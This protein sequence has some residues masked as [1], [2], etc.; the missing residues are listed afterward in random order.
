ML[1]SKTMMKFYIR[2]SFVFFLT[3]ISFGSFAQKT[4]YFGI[5]VI[6]ETSPRA[7]QPSLGINYEQRFSKR[8]GFETDILY[9]KYIENSVFTISNGSE[10]NTSNIRLKESHLSIPALYKF[11]TPF[12]DISAGPSFEFYL[13]WSHTSSNPTIRMTGYSGQNTFNLGL[14]TKVSKRIKLNEQFY[15]EPE[16]RLNPIVTND[17][18]YIGFGL[19]AKYRL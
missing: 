6:L 17:R 16:V 12:I 13:G 15:L 11:Y 8:S 18:A 7:L 14:L 10:V 9:R 19:A 4:K 3:L 2:A 1:I 5:N